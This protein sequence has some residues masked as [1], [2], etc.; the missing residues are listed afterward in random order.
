[1]S[2]SKPNSAV[3][4]CMQEDLFQQ[5]NLIIISWQLL[6]LQPGGQMDLP[7]RQKSFNLI[8]QGLF[9]TYPTDL[10]LRLRS[11]LMDPRSL[12]K[13]INMDISLHLRVPGSSEERIS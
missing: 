7:I 5:T 1:M 2:I 6:I 11:V 4:Q 10:F 9:L 13:T 8:S 3:I 12:V